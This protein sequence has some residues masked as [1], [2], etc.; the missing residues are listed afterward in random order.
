[1]LLDRLDFVQA[2]GFE[3]LEFGRNF[4]RIEAVPDWMEPSEALDFVRE[5]VGA[6]REGRFAGRDERL[7]HEEFARLASAK[8]VRLPSRVSEPEMLSLLREL[9][10]TRHPLSNPAGRPTFIELGQGELARRFGR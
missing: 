5:L 1:M 7:S 3:V 4:F 8:A 10:A 2:H 6:L 9:F